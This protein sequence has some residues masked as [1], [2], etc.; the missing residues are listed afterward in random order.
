MLAVAHSHDPW[1]ASSTALALFGILATLIVGGAG[2]WISYLVAT[3]RYQLWYSLPLCTSLLAAPSGATMKDV[4]VYHKENELQDPHVLQ[5]RL[6]SRSRG[7]IPS[8]AFDQGRPLI[9]DV[10]IPIVAQLSLVRQPHLVP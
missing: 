7:D 3:P 1:Y 10:G 2:A 6:I 4:K 9:L 5:I 8:S